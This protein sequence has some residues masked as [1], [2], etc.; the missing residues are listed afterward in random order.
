MPQTRDL[1]EVNFRSH[2]VDAEIIKKMETVKESVKALALLANNYLPNSRECSIALTKLE[3][4]MFW[5]NAGLARGPAVKELVSKD[6]ESAK[7]Q[8]MKMQENMKN[9]AALKS[10]EQDALS[11]GKKVDAPA[12]DA[13]KN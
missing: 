5:L 2:E 1:I 4:I 9:E 7:A 13:P 3:E 12:P 6:Q 11:K 8:F 10:A